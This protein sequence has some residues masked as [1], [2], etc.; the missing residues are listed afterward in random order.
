MNATPKGKIGRLPK[1][2]QEQVNRR[3][4]D[5]EPGAAVAA[6]LN[7][8]AEVQAIMKA[9][10]HGQPVAA[11]NVSQWRRHGFQKWLQRRE[12]QA[13][14]GEIAELRGVEAAALMEQMAEWVSVRYLMTVRELVAREA[15]GE[16]R[17]KVLREFCRDVVALRRGEHASGRLKL[18]TAYLGLRELQR[19]STTNSQ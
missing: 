19:N 13:V 7:G 16:G 12:A 3:M 17:L 11:H 18:E 9:Q 10:F 8:L 4:E 6:W 14:A 2:L 1:V 5:G 15:D